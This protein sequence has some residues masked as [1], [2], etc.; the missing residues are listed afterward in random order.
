M[1]T[2]SPVAR[3]PRK[4]VAWRLGLTAAALVGLALG[5]LHDTNDYFPLGSMSQYATARD[6]DGTVRSTYMLADNADGEQVR[7]PLNP[8]GV[9]IGRAEIEGQIG[10]IVD[11]P[12]LLQ[13]IANAWAALHPLQPRYEVLYVMRDTYHLVDGAPSGERETV[14]LT[15]W[16]VGP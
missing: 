6:R 14:E 2:A 15:R 9:G 10:R 13:A 7:V 12:S 1:T 3:L 8:T 5:Q 11:D 16:E 4:S